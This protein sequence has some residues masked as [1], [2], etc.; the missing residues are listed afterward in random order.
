MNGTLHNN[1]KLVVKLKSINITI[2]SIQYQNGVPVGK[3]SDTVSFIAEGPIPSANPFT[4]GYSIKLSSGKEYA[5]TSPN[6]FF[7][8]GLHSGTALIQ[9]SNDGEEV[10]L[11]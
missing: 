9:P 11:P 5:I 6:V 3:N 4:S 10:S 7:S 2:G 1:G 8:N